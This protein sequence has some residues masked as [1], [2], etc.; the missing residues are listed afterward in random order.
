MTGE[1]FPTAGGFLVGKGM[2]G[3]K[4][5]L[6]RHQPV[7]G[8]GGR[9]TVCP[10]SA[11][12]LEW[13]FCRVRGETGQ[14]RNETGEVKW[15]H[16]GRAVVHTREFEYLEF[17]WVFKEGSNT[18]SISGVEPRSWYFVSTPSAQVTPQCGSE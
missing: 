6:G 14:A 5:H 11:E 18:L 10:Q 17:G 2:E 15:G 3:G 4:A 9:T 13:H 16:S 7:Q 8:P 1:S 12:R